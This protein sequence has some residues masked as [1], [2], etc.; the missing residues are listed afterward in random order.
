MTRTMTMTR[1]AMGTGRGAAMARSRAEGTQ[2]V[3]RVVGLAII[4]SVFVAI[5]S[6]A[7][8]QLPAH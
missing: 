2:L 3:R 6:H 1:R 7:F 8:T 4:A 5:A